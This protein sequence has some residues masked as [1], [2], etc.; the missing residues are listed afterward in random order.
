MFTLPNSIITVNTCHGIHLLTSRFLSPNNRRRQQRDGLKVV[1]RP[2][3]E[4]EKTKQ[5]EGKA[6]TKYVAGESCF[7]S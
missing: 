2:W 3:N 7:S 4:E 6:F 1:G 5:E